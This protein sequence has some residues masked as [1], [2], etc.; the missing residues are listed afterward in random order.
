[1]IFYQFHAGTEKFWSSCATMISGLCQTILFLEK[2]EPLSEK[3]Q[4]A[5]NVKHL[6][7]ATGITN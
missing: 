1:M 2:T 6:K 3:K 7:K 5:M 4:C